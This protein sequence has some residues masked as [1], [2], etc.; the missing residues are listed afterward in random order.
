MRGV[1]SPSS[2]ATSNAVPVADPTFFFVIFD[3]DVRLLQFWHCLLH[4][5][6][7]HYEHL[8]WSFH[9]L[10]RSYL[11]RPSWVESCSHRSCFLDWYCWILDFSRLLHLARVALLH[12]RVLRFLS[13]S[14]SAGSEGLP[15]GFHPH[16]HAVQI[17]PFQSLPL[18]GR[19]RHFKQS[20]SYLWRFRECDLQALRWKCQGLVSSSSGAN[21]FHCCSAWT[22]WNKIRK[23]TR[24]REANHKTLPKRTLPLSLSA[25]CTHVDVKTQYRANARCK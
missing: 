18:K 17:Q 14:E 6:L 21:G 24:E 2:I 10:L 13:G 16:P 23:E 5:L 22:T 25:T 20:R 19:H 15:G 12:Y 7:C 1:S 3:R 9:S 8:S 11:S 4:S